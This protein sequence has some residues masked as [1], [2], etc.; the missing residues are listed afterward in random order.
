MKKLHN[1]MGFGVLAAASL[2]V[3]AGS[4]R[5]TGPLLGDG[6]APVITSEPTNQR[7]SVGASVKFSIMADG[8]PTLH[9]R[10][11]HNGAELA[12]GG[13]ISGADTNTVTINPVEAGDAGNYD[14]VVTN[15]FGGVTSKPGR[16]RVLQTTP[17][18]VGN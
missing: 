17:F 13:R 6:S 4:G 15:D 18:P 7:V 3:L 9:Y 12:D 14:C 16:L 5:S 10:W 2:A 11:R 8:S 1:L